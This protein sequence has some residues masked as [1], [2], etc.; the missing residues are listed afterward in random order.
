MEQKLEN[1]GIIDLVNNPFAI[2]LKYQGLSFTPHRQKQLPAL[3]GKDFETI[4]NTL[5]VNDGKYV[6][7]IAIRWGYAKMIDGRLAHTGKWI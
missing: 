5:P 4:V 3:F 7:F 6:A 1:E 2:S